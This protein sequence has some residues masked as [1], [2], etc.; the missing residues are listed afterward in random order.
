[1]TVE[2]F[3]V[4][5][6]DVV[7]DVTVVVGPVCVEVTVEVLVDVLVTVE[8]VVTVEVTGASDVV[9][10]VVEDAVE[11][12]E[13]LPQRVVPALSTESEPPTMN[14]LTGI[15]ASWSLP[16]TPQPVPYET[17]VCTA[18]QEPDCSLIIAVLKV[19]SGKLKVLLASSS[20][21]E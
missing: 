17:A 3:V 10:D 15:A 1:V 16:S 4:V 5:E 20:D 11:L 2:V 18:P 12:D 19:T 21:R 7:V 14:S 6:G 8:V 13:L 9:D